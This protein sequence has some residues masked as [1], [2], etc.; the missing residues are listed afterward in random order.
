MAI[1]HR[2]LCIPILITLTAF[3]AFA[4]QPPATDPK[5]DQLEKNLDQLLRQ[6][7]EIRQQLDSIKG[8]QPETVPDLT[9]VDVPPAAATAATST[10]T[11]AKETPP[12]ALT[13]VQTVE[14]VP[15]PG[16]S[17]VFNPDI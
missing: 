5:I 13:D 3:P 2:F 8:T 1:G 9:K 6:A 7:A 11:P 12:T 16:A 4:Q 17:K 15:N 10:E 14:N